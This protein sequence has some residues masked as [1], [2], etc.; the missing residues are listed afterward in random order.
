MD[1][2]DALINEAASHHLIVNDDG[3]S[4]WPVAALGGGDYLEFH[5]AK[6]DTSTTGSR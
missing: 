4:N 6:N 3:V 2:R 1:D 5:K